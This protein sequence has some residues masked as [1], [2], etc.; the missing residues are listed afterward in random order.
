[1]GAKEQLSAEQR[2]ERGK[3]LLIYGMFSLVVV[4]IVAVF[5]TTWLIMAP[6]GMTGQSI[7]VTVIVGLIAIVASVFVWFAYTKGILKE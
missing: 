1:M 7:Q 6:V 5:L 4:T 3:R 2:A